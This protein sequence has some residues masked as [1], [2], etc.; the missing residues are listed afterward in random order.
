[1]ILSIYRGV[2]SKKKVGNSKNRRENEDL[3]KKEIQAQT[4]M[5]PGSSKRTRGVG[6]IQS[7]LTLDLMA[8]KHAAHGNKTQTQGNRES[9][10]YTCRTMNQTMQIKKRMN[11]K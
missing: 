5:D 8:K 11:Q 10:A 9:Q 2:E 7:L 3:H 4:K 1:V 6:L